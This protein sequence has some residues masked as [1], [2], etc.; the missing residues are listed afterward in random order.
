VEPSSES[1]VLEVRRGRHNAHAV[2]PGNGKRKPRK[3]RRLVLVPGVLVNGQP[4]AFVSP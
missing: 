4:Y 3:R 2:K 1:P